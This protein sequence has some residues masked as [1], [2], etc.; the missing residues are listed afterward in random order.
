MLEWA[1]KLSG[2]KEGA[3]GM[4]IQKMP[5]NQ[6]AGL[7]YLRWWKWKVS[8]PS[9]MTPLSSVLSPTVRDRHETASSFPSDIACLA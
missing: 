3:I 7:S 6:R 2:C 5:S 4:P 8:F 1:S 9:V